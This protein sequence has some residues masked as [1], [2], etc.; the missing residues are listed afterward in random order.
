MKKTLVIRRSGRKASVPNTRQTSKSIC[1]IQKFWKI[2]KNLRPSN[3]TTDTF[4]PNRIR[5]RGRD[6]ICPITQDTI[7]CN[8]VFKFVSA[9]GHV[10]AYDVTALMHYLKSS[11]NFSCPC[12]RQAFTRTDVLRVR[13]KIKRLG[14]PNLSFEAQTLVSDFEM[15]WRLRRTNLEQ[16]YRVLAIEN[17]CGLVMTEA[18]DVCANL[19]LSTQEASVQLV[20]Y[21]LPEWKML[22]D[23]FMRLSLNDAKAML[24]ADR[25]KITRLELSDILDPHGLIHYIQDAITLKLTS[26]NRRQQTVFEFSGL[27]NAIRDIFSSTYSVFPPPPAPQ[28]MNRSE[29]PPHWLGTSRINGTSAPF[30]RIV[31]IFGDSFVSTTT[32]STAPALVP[33]RSYASFSSNEDS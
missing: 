3:N 27:D 25:E 31:D 15:R 29:R 11:N 26:A 20:N 7:E 4:T 13:E 1:T 32:V 9:S 18:L 21:L 16:A 30:R 6:V 28:T 10:H 14:I 24:I 23:D 33:S 2:Y 12:T 8:D 22:V 5:S 19:S 17:S